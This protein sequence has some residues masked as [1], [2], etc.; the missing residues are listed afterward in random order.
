MNYFILFIVLF[1]ILA[2]AEPECDYA[3]TSAEVLQLSCDSFE[4]ANAILEK[5]EVVP[6]RIY[7][8][9]KEEYVQKNVAA[10]NVPQE[11]W[12][13]YIMGDITRFD[14]GYVRRGL[15]GTGGLDTN[16]YGQK[17]YRA[18]M[19][20]S[21]KDECRKPERVVSLEEIE[22]DSRFQ[23]WFNKKKQPMS[24]ESFAE[25]CVLDYAKD[26]ENKKC[27]KIVGEF[28]EDA[29][30]GVI[31][32]HMSRKSFYIRDRNCIENIRGTPSDWIEI[33]SNTPNLFI[34]RCGDYNK[35]YMLRA[36][37]SNLNHA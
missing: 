9:G 7:H 33:F 12:D 35:V 27:G 22:K 24:M 19:E 36:L 8:F 16:N 5:K 30:I 1:Q 23:A 13:K 26:Y 11:D 21:I 2:F 3:A 6:S 10:K 29:K 14:L 32:D 25:N 28:L 17:G 34:S 15:Y 31:Y 20:I 18:L 4:I 37:L